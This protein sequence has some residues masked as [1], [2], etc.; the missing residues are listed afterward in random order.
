MLICNPHSK[1]TMIILSYGIERTLLL[2]KNWPIIQIFQTITIIYNKIN[3]SDLMVLIMWITL[4]LIMEMYK[5]INNNNNSS[6]NK[7]FKNRM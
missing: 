4:T 7:I 2:Q 5:I 1:I 3:K 6:R